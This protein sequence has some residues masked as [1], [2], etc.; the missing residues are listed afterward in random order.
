MAMAYSVMATATRL[1][2][3]NCFMYETLIALEVRIF[4][5]TALHA[6]Y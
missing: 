4:F 5:I 6:A 1:H 3:L 2:A